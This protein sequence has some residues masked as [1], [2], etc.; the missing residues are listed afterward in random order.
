MH[1]V[2]TVGKVIVGEHVM[3]QVHIG[4]VGEVVAQHVDDELRQEL[5]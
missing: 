1:D 4:E 2:H 3:H 5:V